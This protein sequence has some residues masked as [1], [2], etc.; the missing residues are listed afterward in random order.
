MCAACCYSGVIASAIP[1][2]VEIRR[3]VRF[4][5]SF[6]PERDK[7]VNKRFICRSLLGNAGVMHDLA[8]RPCR[9]TTLDPAPGVDALSRETK[10]PPRIATELT[11][12][13]PSA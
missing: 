13:L 8:V 5:S 4:I 7:P 3:V 6:L 1:D 12:Q 10:R 11:T 9:L 2:F